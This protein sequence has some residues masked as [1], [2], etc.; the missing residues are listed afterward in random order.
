MLGEASR[1]RGCHRA[2]EQQNHQQGAAV[3]HVVQ[4]AAVLLLMPTDF[5]IATWVG[6]CVLVIFVIDVVE[7]YKGR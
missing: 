3:L 2:T 6:A 7:T 1:R 4:D 5:M